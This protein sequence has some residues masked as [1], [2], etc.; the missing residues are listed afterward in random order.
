MEP[1]AQFIDLP[2][3]APGGG[4]LRMH[5]LDW[6]GSGPPLLLLHGLSSNA[7]I[8]DFVAPILT[9]HF[10]VI[11]ADQRGH[12]LTDVPRDAYSFAEVTGDITALLD[13]L[14]I[15]PPI[16][17]GHSW[18]GGV[19]VQFAADSPAR[20]RGIV[21]VDGG[22]MDV[23]ARLTWEQAEKEMRPP[24][25]DG[26]PIKTFLTAARNFPDMAD[27]WSDQLQEMFLSNF[28]VRD[29]KVYRRLPIDQH[30]QV[31]RA[32]YDQ[33]THGLLERI[34]C[35]ALAL[36]ARREPSNDLARKWME[37]REKS[38]EIAEQRLRFGRI[39]WMEDSI[40]DIPIQRPAEL[41]AAITEFGRDLA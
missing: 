6:G 16:V 32:L 36:L 40:H 23:A 8:W 5:T 13:H 4:A 24:E 38:A 10:R 41:A 31:V 7:R 2:G 26:I 14:A 33:G 27:R 18:G 39:V 25:L 20:T 21:L 17:V 12:G 11:A 28:E 9:Q 37:W 3:R 1:N 35:P 15:D 29:D 22:V 30:M 19:A 34:A